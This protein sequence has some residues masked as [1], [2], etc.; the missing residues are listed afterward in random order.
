[1]W[2]LT[3]LGIPVARAAARTAFCR[4]LSCKWWQR[5]TPLRGYTDSEV[6]RLRR[7]FSDLV[8]AAGPKLEAKFV[9]AHCFGGYTTNLPLDLAMDEGILAHKQDGEPMGMSHGWPLRLVVPSIYAWKSAKWVNGIELMAE[10]SPGFWEQ[11]GYHNEG[12]PWKR[13]NQRMRDW[14]INTQAK[15]GHMTG[16]WHIAGGHSGQG[17]RV[18]STSMATM[19]LEVYYRHMPLYRKQASEDDF[20]L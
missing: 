10:D 8:A 16:S 4:P 19:I 6:T 12:D 20:P 17:G 5:T 3:R 7:C 13:W 9:M 1:M 18:Y 11:R 2:Q 15:K 14:L